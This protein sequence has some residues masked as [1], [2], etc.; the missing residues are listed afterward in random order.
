MYWRRWNYNSNMWGQ[1]L[2]SQSCINI[3]V[4]CFVLFLFYVLVT[5]QV[6]TEL[7]IDA[8]KSQFK[9]ARVEASRRDVS[10]DIH[11]SVCSDLH[12]PNLRAATRRHTC[13]RTRYV[14]KNLSS[15][16]R[17]CSTLKNSSK[18]SVVVWKNLPT[19]GPLD[20]QTYPRV[21]LKPPSE[22]GLLLG[23]SLGLRPREI[24]LSSPASLGGFRFTLG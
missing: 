13:S 5:Y 14:N 11:Y 3:N 6:S 17:L 22:A 21:I 1:F 10:P 8:T 15:S 24:P 4:F 19:G 2:G 18:S 23:I 7:S 9:S 20:A 12:S 16:L